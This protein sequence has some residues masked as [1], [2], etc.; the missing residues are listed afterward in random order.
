[1]ARMPRSTAATPCS[2]AKSTIRPLKVATVT[3]LSVLVASLSIS[4]RSETV[5]SGFLTG[6]TRMPTVSWSNSLEPRWIRSTWPFVGGSKVPGYRALTGILLL[7]QHF[8]SGQKRGLPPAKKRQGQ[9]KRNTAT[10][11]AKFIALAGALFR[12]RVTCFTLVRTEIVLRCLHPRRL[13][14]YGASAPEVPTAMRQSADICAPCCSGRLCLLHCVAG[15]L[16]S[17][18]HLYAIAGGCHQHRCSR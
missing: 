8:T 10:L 9:M 1:M 3:F 7:F 14:H 18:F 12:C 17:Q 13:R 5:N 11:L 2:R 15:R 4:T 6:F 16:L